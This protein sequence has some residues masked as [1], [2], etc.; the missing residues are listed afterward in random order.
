MSVTRQ[1]YKTAQDVYVIGGDVKIADQANPLNTNITG[2]DVM[3]PVDIQSHYQTT[4]QTH[5]GAMIAPSGATS[6]GTYIDA[7]GFQEIGV[8]ATI[9]AAVMTEVH[10][11]WSNDGINIHGLEMFPASNPT[12]KAYSTATKGRYFRVVLKNND[13]AARTMS[14]W[15]FLKA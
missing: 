14:A 12:S 10:L 7:A 15:A 9:D 13:A 4:V 1:G 2:S 6:S 5:T 3:Q 11:H 8:T